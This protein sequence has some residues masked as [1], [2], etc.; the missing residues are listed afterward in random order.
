MTGLTWSAVTADVRSPFVVDT[1]ELDRRAGSTRH[2]HRT[3][4]APDGLAIQ[5][6]RVDAGST[7]VLDVDLDSIVGGLWVAGTVGVE[8]VTECVRCLEETRSALSVPLE[9]LFVT[10]EDGGSGGSRN[11]SRA[12]RHTAGRVGLA[13]DETGDGDEVFALDGDLL[14]LSQLVRDAIVTELPTRPLCSQD[15]AGL[16]MDGTRADAGEVP[17]APADPRWSALADW[18]GGAP[19]SE[20]GAPQTSSGVTASPGTRRT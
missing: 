3:A 13:E 2:L 6:S 4:D 1:R 11:G 20:P 12:D 14:D 7:M 10:P 19:G 5:S 15:C 8:L 18:A 9:A 16:R 17:S